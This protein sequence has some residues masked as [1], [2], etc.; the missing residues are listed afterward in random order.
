MIKKIYN[1]I[2]DF[3]Q[4]YCDFQVEESEFLDGTACQS[5]KF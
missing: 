1:K 5:P 3:N 2:K 4:A